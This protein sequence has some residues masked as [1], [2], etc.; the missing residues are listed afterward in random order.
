[1]VIL[2]APCPKC[3]TTGTATMSEVTGHT[4]EVLRRDATQFDCPAGCTFGS[5]RD[6][7]PLRNYGL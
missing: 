4:G 7:R 1:M 6:L 5:V 3:G 2:E